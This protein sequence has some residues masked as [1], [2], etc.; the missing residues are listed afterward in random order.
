VALPDVSVVVITYN[1]AGRLPTAVR[2]VTGQTLNNLE[3]LVVDD[4]S[5]DDTPAV[6]EALS[7]EDPRVRYLR[8]PTNS[9]SGSA[10]RNAG[11]DASHAPWVM[12]L[13]SDDTYDRHACKNLL[14]AV[15]QTGAE[16]GLG[17]CVRVSAATGQ[18]S[19]WYAEL[20]ERRTSYAS[21]LE[22]PQLLWDTISVNKIY[23][24]SLLDRGPL[25]FPEGMFYEDQVFTA[26]A[27][28]LARGIAVVP[29]VVY[30]W[31]T[32]DDGPLSAT[33]RRHELSN[34]EDRLAAN[35]MID[36]F[37]DAHD[38]GHLLVA[39]KGEKFLR[40]DL[41]LYLNDLVR[42]DDEAR[43]RF[44][45]LAAPYLETIPA[46]AYAACSQVEN[47]A[48]LVLRRRDVEGLLSAV[49]YL[50]NDGRLSTA[51]HHEGD[52][53]F[54]C[55]RH[56]DDPQARALL[57]VT[58]LQVHRIP[59]PQQRL[60]HRAVL[61]RTGGSRFVVEGSSRLQ[62]GTLSPTD[63]VSVALSVRLGG[64]QQ[65]LDRKAEV[66][67][68]EDGL[69]WSAEVDLA[70]LPFTRQRTQVWHLEL[71][72]STPHGTNTSPVQADVA[73]DTLVRVRPPLSPLVGNQ[74]AL[75]TN[76]HGNVVMTLGHASAAA[77]RA[78]DRVAALMR[79]PR[80][81]AVRRRVRRLRPGTVVKHALYDHLLTRLPVVPG[82]VVFESQL[83]KQYSDS[84]RAI[85]EGLR[86][87]GRRLNAVWSYSA[88]PAGFPPEARLVRRESLGWYRA[89]ARAEFWVDNQG[90]PRHVT[91]RAGTTYLQTWHGTPLKTLGFDEPRIRQQAAAEQQELQQMIDRWDQLVVP[92][93]YFEEVFVPAHRYK[94]GLVRSG[95]PRND[96]LFDDAAKQSVRD[97]LGLPHDRTIALYAPT[98]REQDRNRKGP[99][100]LAL[101]LAPMD[102]ALSSE[103]FLLVRP[104]YLNRVQV[105]GRFA[106]FVRD[107]SD[108]Q[109][110]SELMLAADV[111][112]TDYS[113]LMFD[114]ANLQRPMVF[115]TYDYEDYANDKRGLYFDLA[116]EAPGPL[117]RTTAEVIALL[118]DLPALKEKYADQAA[119]FR[120]RFC[121]FEDGHATQRV[122]DAVFGER[123]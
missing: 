16:L 121:S 17:R 104:H 28:G 80:A 59:L 52:R 62:T 33:N 82:L 48:Y 60:A 55:D 103:L 73:P 58:D 117:P 38:E 45:E 74:L 22:Q 120:E 19:P 68:A 7:A 61:R 6:A 113:S 35:R 83:G 84:P 88:S 100:R 123:P 56:L 87:S 43:G 79:T 54:W 64:T 77:Q 65:R 39:T 110:V 109:D 98:F 1:D 26:Q 8:L 20:T 106:H 69:S 94:G 97:R 49:D 112:I 5:D 34:L 47:I 70:A 86:D 122:I 57:D 2:S 71:R 102:I 4:G 27:Y 107:V 46:E 114:Y 111:L 66:V 40:H 63:D 11:I 36:D 24:R 51:L 75:T 18:R 95:L 90:F 41:R 116:A 10:P 81:R 67:P 99:I 105:P 115:Y 29:N 30:H 9:G 31:M 14:L 118:Q 15:E 32:Y 78:S 76:V 72:L 85:Y 42:Q 23:A 44:V 119:R 96:V 37:L 21:V 93:A 13:D 50:Q 53:V 91:K 108:V 25:R 101:E 3:V 89:L 92:N 12:F